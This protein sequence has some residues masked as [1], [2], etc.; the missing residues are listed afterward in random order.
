MIY[1]LM[2]DLVIVVHLGFVVFVGAGPLL[3]W[4]WPQLLWPHALSLMWAVA[5]VSVG[6]TCPLTPLEKYFHRLAGEE[7]Y[8]GGFIDHYLE[9]VVYPE[10]FT[11]LLRA[12]A[13]LAIVIGYAGLHRGRRTASHISGIV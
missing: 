7:G 2:A 6:F 5:I 1:R 12:V 3:A 11:P 10:S 4:R 13:F 8:A 9:G